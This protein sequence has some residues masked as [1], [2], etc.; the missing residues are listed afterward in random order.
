VVKKPVNG[1]VVFYEK[2]LRRLK[3]YYEGDVENVEKIMKK[4]NVG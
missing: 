1:K 3:K 4:M 2:V